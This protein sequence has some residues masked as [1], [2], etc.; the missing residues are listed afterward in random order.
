MDLN[1]MNDLNHLND[2]NDLTHKCNDS[3]PQLS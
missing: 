3:F 1:E 2:H